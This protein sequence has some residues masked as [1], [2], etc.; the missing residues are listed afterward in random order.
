MLKQTL[1]CNSWF[2]EHV[3][4]LQQLSFISVDGDDFA[5]SVQNPAIAQTEVTHSA[6]QH[7]KSQSLLV[8]KPH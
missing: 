8:Y 4:V 1:D 7:N 5:A 6:C 3:R 2:P